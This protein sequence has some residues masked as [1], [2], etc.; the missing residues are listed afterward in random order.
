MCVSVCV[1]VRVHVGISACESLRGKLCA[2]CTIHTGHT[3]GVQPNRTEPHLGGGVRG[4]LGLGEAVEADVGVVAVEPAAGGGFR[5]RANSTNT[6]LWV[7]VCG[8]REWVW[9]GVH[10]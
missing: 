10:V 5:P 9:M 2:L 8:V 3:H 4:G 6:H 1:R 7:R